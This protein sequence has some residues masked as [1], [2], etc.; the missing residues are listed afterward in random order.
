MIAEPLQPGL[1]DHRQ[2]AL[3]VFVGQADSFIDL[4]ILEE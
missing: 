4:L 1:N 2:V 3:L